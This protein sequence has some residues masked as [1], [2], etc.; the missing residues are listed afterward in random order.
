MSDTHS[1]LFF[2]RTNGKLLFAVV[3]RQKDRQ[4]S[5]SGSMLFWESEAF[6]C[7][8][9]QAWHGPQTIRKRAV[10]PLLANVPSDFLHIIQSTVEFNKMGFVVERVIHDGLGEPD[11]HE[12]RCVSRC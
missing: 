3:Q 12:S 4:L 2:S 11:G 9:F 10:S 5:S 1:T 6:P 8:H 7:A